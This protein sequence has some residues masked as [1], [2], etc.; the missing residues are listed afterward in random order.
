M[1]MSVCNWR[2]VS[3]S[4]NLA[5]VASLSIL[6]FAIPGCSDKGQSTAVPEASTKGKIVIKGSNTIG[7]ELAPRLIAEFKKD[8]PTAAVELE[9]KATGYGLAALMAGQCN[10][11]AA[12]RPPIKDELELAKSR[13]VELSD[14]VIGAYAV[15]VIVNSDCPVTGLK[16]GQVR[17]IFTGVV[18]NWKDVGGSDAPIH[19][20]S[21]DPISG[22]A[23]GF[24]ELAMENKPYASGEKTFTNYAGIV[25]AVA[26]DPNGIGYCSIVLS[27]SSGI[28]FLPIDGVAPS[29]ATVNEGKYPYARVLHFYTNKGK[30]E[31]AAKVFIDFVLSPKGQEIVA[32]TGNVPRK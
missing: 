23:L 3:G 5:K 22:T 28:K 20:C 11:A 16:R 26:Q 1:K 21:R 10:V 31:A 14:Y 27:N 15:A 17:D 29:M 8:H 9:S 25:Q 24:K 4:R 13:N 18:Q 2:F 12:S 19:I 30:E 6:L 7:E 32:Q